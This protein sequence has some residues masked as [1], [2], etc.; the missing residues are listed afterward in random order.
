MSSNRAKPA[1][2]AGP[3]RRNT[4]VFIDMENLFGGYAGDVAS[5]PMRQL[6]EEVE[7]V[8]AR[9]GVLSAVALTRA[10]ANWSDSRL[11][12]YRREMMEHGV[13]PVQVFS[14]GQALKNAADIEL[15]VDALSLARDTI[16][17]DVF[18]IVS[19]D[20][21]FVP[22]I[23]RLHALGRFVMVVTTAAADKDVKRGS[24]L[25]RAV[26]DY[27]HIVGEE[28]GD[29]EIASP[30]STSPAYADAAQ[31]T[32][33]TRELACLRIRELVAAE[34]SLL[35]DDGE[36]IN[37]ALLGQRM[38]SIWPN[39]NASQVGFK[40]LSKL[41]EE[42]LGR[43]LRSVGVP[44]ATEVTKPETA[45]GP[46][47]SMVTLADTPTL[48]AYRQVMSEVLKDP[49]VQSSLASYTAVGGLP[50]VRADAYFKL[51][52]PN[53]S[54]RQA[55][56]PQL[57]TALR[58]ALTGTEWCLVTNSV[59]DLFLAARSM[60]AERRVADLPTEELGSLSVVRDV[61]A[62]GQP[63]LRFDSRTAIAVVAE[64]LA[65]K[66]PVAKLGDLVD[67]VAE[68]YPAVSAERLR[69]ALGLCT[70]AHILV[71]DGIGTDRIFSL[72]DD[73]AD[74]SGLLARLRDA[75]E[76]ALASRGWQCDEGV[77]DQLVPSPLF[78]T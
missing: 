17:I 10:Y 20:G 65:E 5:V 78:L 24:K 38:K 18:V 55:G 6:L 26:A 8:A 42:A 71:T 56:F 14:F 62:R 74:F 40:T 15:V 60:P 13:E 32:A 77:L 66:R 36:A 12:A 23:R 9:L 16:D 61:L 3:P 37:S 31:A 7:V 75:A 48:K 52:A 76:E 70:S 57:K 51:V 67:G 30:L 34:P 49:A 4:A 64:Y 50:L 21:G 73:I 43:P 2:D 59:T 25:L 33:P 68:A 35:K 22:L 54:Y 11:G 1:V 58:N 41:A 44:S 19:G 27:F 53:C 69:I 45:D 63:S 46:P 72:I 28:L 29:P 47:L 39:F